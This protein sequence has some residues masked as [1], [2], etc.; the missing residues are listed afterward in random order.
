MGT[1]TVA[2]SRA[3]ARSSHAANGSTV[4]RWW[5]V[6]VLDD[7]VELDSKFD[8]LDIGG[9]KLH[10]TFLSCSD[11]VTMLAELF[12]ILLESPHDGDRNI[13]CTS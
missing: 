9:S 13:Y 1:A 7:P 2:L 4:W 10:E 5:N 8:G 11:T 3:G 6:S 12:S